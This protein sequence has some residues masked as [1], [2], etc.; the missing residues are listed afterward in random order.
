VP[1]SGGASVCDIV[2]YGVAAGT[3][4]C[5]GECGVP[6]D[7]CGLPLGVGLSGR[8][9][10]GAYVNVLNCADIVQVLLGGDPSV[11]AGAPPPGTQT[12]SG[13]F[14]YQAYCSCAPST[15]ACTSG[16]CVYAASCQTTI[17]NTLGGCPSFT[18]TRSALNTTCDMPANKCRSAASA[19][20]TD[21]DCDGAPV[22]DSAGVI[23]RG[24][25]CACSTGACYL[26]CAKDLDCQNGYSCDATQKLCVPSPCANDAQCFSQLGKAR[27]R[28]KK[29]VCGILCAVDHDCGPSGDLPG[30]P[31][32]GTV[33]GPDGVCAPVGCV[34][35]ADCSGTAGP[36]LFCVTPPANTVRSAITN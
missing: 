15:W 2:A 4:T 10:A 24:G 36:R 7:C 17:A 32:N 29:G 33:C 19:C 34:S 26:K 12:A 1:S 23:C 14:F 9:D 25:D 31:F 20:A 22:S 11:C 21:T 18:R 28:C 27:A 5:S 35:D 8:T 13:C 30:Q 6:A 3:K 16:R